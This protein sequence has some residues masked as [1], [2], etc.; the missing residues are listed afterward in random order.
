MFFLEFSEKKI[1]RIA[2]W[3]MIVILYSRHLLKMHFIFTIL[4]LN[5]WVCSSYGGSLLA[6]P[7]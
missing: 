3:K 2:K 1:S 7:Y 4:I 5:M 6:G